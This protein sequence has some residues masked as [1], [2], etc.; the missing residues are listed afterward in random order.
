M[1]PEST[2][3]NKK[4]ITLWKIEIFLEFFQEKNLK[5]TKINTLVR[6]NLC[7]ALIGMAKPFIIDPSISKS[8]ATPLNASLS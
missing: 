4:V 5:V 6:N 8:S 7:S 2:E 1:A 3:Q